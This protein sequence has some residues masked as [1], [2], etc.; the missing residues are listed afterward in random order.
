MARKKQCKVFVSY[1]RH[2]EALVK[3]L[4]GLLGVAAENAVFLDVDALKPGDCWRSEIENAVR[5][6]SVFVLC[7]CCESSRSE[8]VKAEVEIALEDAR[9]RLVPV[10]FCATPLPA[11]LKERQWVNLQGRVTHIC[12]GHDAVVTPSMARS[13]V[14]PGA[15]RATGVLPDQLLQLWLPI[16]LVLSFLFSVWYAHRS[17]SPPEVTCKFLQGPRRGEVGIVFSEKFDIRPGDECA[18]GKGSTGIITQLPAPRTTAPS[19]ATILLLLITVAI[20]SI[21]TIIVRLR[22]RYRRSETSLIAERAVAYFQN[23]SAK[24]PR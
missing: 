5:D 2:D 24:A 17:P 15:P 12:N 18:D 14:K 22:M 11:P 21:V 20:L 1:S 3:P 16:L 9:K 13:E 8:F 4:A 7:W 19:P 10:L 6:S 23:L